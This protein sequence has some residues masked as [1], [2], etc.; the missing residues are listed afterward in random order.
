[1]C[2]FTSIQCKKYFEKQTRN[3]TYTLL[4]EDYHIYTKHIDVLN[5]QLIVHYSCHLDSLIFGCDLD[6][7][8]EVADIDSCILPDMIKC[9]N[10]IGEEI[11]KY[12]K[13]IIKNK[14]KEQKLY[15]L[16]EKFNFCLNELLENNKR[17]SHIKEVQK[18][19]LSIMNSDFLEDIVLVI[20]SKNNQYFFFEKECR[21][22]LVEKLK[23][24]I[25]LQKSMKQQI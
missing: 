25:Q 17:I 22:D 23:Y 7:N 4:N 9:K 8:F 14:K 18:K 24:I 2:S 1:M 12:N 21:F 15:Q 6:S 20:Q 13:K 16:Q 3:G 5:E 10:Y 11:N 19:R